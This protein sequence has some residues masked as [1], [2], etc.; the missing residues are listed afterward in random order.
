MNS[1]ILSGLYKPERIERRKKV[2]KPQRSDPFTSKGFQ[3]YDRKIKSHSVA[4]YLKT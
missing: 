4:T 2:K 1:K 3:S